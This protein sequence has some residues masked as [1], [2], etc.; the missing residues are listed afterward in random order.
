MKQLVI[1]KGKGII[2]LSDLKLSVDEQT[3]GQKPINGI[4]HYECFDKVLELCTKYNLNHIMDSIY[5][6][7]GGS[8]NFPGITRIPKYEEEYGTDNIKAF[9]LRRLIGRVMIEDFSDKISDT[10]IGI[11]FHQGGIQLAYGQN[12]RICQNMCI[13]GGRLISSNKMESI[14]KMFEVL[15]HYIQNHEKQREIDQTI[16]NRMMEIPFSYEDAIRMVGD[17][18][19]AA[20]N[21][22]YRKGPTPPFNIG[23]VSK[24][25]IKLLNEYDEIPVHSKN[26]D[27]M[28]LWN[29]YNIGTNLHKATESG[30][31]TNLMPMNQTLG[32]YIL[33][34]YDFKDII[35]KYHLELN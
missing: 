10:A 18:E 2:T 20:V 3:M 1:E 6:A 35:D 12:V 5:V 32:N 13:F 28:K 23:Q 30:D 29:V 26:G 11:S 33:K 15:E 22:A 34:T 21:N 8:S 17:L 14:S 7:D 25:T 27:G 19:I 24:F 9:I 31:I 4:R 16:L